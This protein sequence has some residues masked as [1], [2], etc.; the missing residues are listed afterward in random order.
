VKDDRSLGAFTI[1]RREVR[2]FNYKQIALVQNFAAQ[3]V[4]AMENA[5]LITETRE[6]LEQQTATAEVLGIIN[7][8]P[9]NLASVFDAMLDK[10]LSLCEAAH[11]A[12]YD[13]DGKVSH[14]LAAR[15][16]PGYVAFVHDRNPNHLPGGTPLSDA[17]LNN[18]VVH[19]A[20]AR[21]HEAYRLR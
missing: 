17:L 21:A 14:P 9:G 7:S 8:S 18:E 6:A 19:V 11:G 2:P 16:A 10:A 13:Y 5:R 20:D 4:I 1:Y 12:L 15:G 3:A